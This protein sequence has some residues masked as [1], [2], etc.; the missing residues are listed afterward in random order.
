MV[1]RPFAQFPCIHVEDDG[2]GCHEIYYMGPDDGP[3]ARAY[4]RGRTFD[5][6]VQELLAELA[7]DLPQ[8]LRDAGV[9]AGPAVP[10]IEAREGVIQAEAQ[11]V[12]DA[13]GGSPPPAGRPA[14]VSRPRRLLRRDRAATAA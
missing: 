4:G 3:A 2:A 8:T 5:E 9:V 6:A 7:V 12:R 11:L 13:S 10:D 1:G 14:D